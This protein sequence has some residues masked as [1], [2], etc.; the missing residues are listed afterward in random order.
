M[1]CCHICLKVCRSTANEPQIT[2]SMT[3]AAMAVEDAA[4][5][6][7]ALSHAKSR[8]QI[9]Q[10]LAIF[11]KVRA[12]RASQMQQASAINGKL[13]HFADGPEQEARD[14]FM[15]D[16]IEGNPIHES[17]NQWSDPTTQAWA[18]GYD[19]VDEIRRAVGRSTCI[20]V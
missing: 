2:D 7:E 19:A 5:L 14:L 9:P 6:R 8:K 12:K 3:G 1:Q 11:E 17:A 15:R 18:Y 10:V 20:F 13:W 4:A 16:E